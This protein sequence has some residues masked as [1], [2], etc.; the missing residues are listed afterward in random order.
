MPILSPYQTY[1]LDRVSRRK[2][3]VSIANSSTT[4]SPCVLSPQ[5][6]S[7]ISRERFSL[8]SI[9]TRILSGLTS[10]IKSQMLYN[11][12]IQPW[13]F[14]YERFPLHAKLLELVRQPL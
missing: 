13:L 7:L 3:S 2:T 14:M 4:E 1:K 11:D 12:I 6:A 8:L 9:L 5:S 10:A